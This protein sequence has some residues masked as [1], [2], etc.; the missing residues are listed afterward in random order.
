MI[1]VTST[2]SSGIHSFFTV[3]LFAV[4]RFA[5][6]RFALLLFAVLLFALL[7]FTSLFIRISL[8]IFL[9]FTTQLESFKLFC[10]NE[11]FDVIEA[12]IKEVS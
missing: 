3:L 2:F 7:R 9:G 8:A 6:L 1:L 5:L 12:G 11:A 4:L 10:S